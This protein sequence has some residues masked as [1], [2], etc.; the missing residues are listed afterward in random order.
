MSECAASGCG[1]PIEGVE[2]QLKGAKGDRGATGA[3]GPKGDTGAA[4]ND[5]RDGRDGATLESLRI[6][7]GDAFVDEGI[8]HNPATLFVKLTDGRE[9]IQGVDLQA[10]AG[11]DGRD[12]HDGVDG[13]K[14]DTGPAGTAGVD[15]RDGRDGADGATGPKGDTGLQGPK[16]DAGPQGIQGIQGQRG[17]TGL[18]GD[19]GLQGPKGDKGDKGDTGPQGIAGPQ[20]PAGPQGEPGTGGGGELTDDTRWQ[21]SDLSDAVNVSGNR[22]TLTLRRGDGTMTGADLNFKTINGQSTVGVGDITAAG[23]Q[24]PKGDKGDTGPAGADGMQG[25][26]GIQGPA[27][28]KGDTGLQGPAGPK[29]D[30]GATGAQGPKGDGSDDDLRWQQSTLDNTVI[31][32]RNNLTLNRGDGTSSTVF[33]L[34]K[35]INGNSLLGSG[36]IAVNGQDDTS[37]QQSALSTAIA[38]TTDLSVSFQRGNSSSTALRQP[39]KTVNGSPVI[40]T[41]NISV[42]GAQGPTGPAGPSLTDIHFDVLDP[43]GQTLDVGR[44]VKGDKGDTG[45]QGPQ[46]P[47]GPAGGSGDDGKYLYII[48][49][50]KTLPYY[51]QNRDSAI[52]LSF[53]IS[54]KN[55]RVVNRSVEDI[56]YTIG[57]AQYILLSHT[58]ILLALNAAVATF[59]HDQFAVKLVYAATDRLVFAILKNRN[60]FIIV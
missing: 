19:T 53:N 31:G 5:G 7:Q 58:E 32:N 25:P 39:F 45:P 47:Q 48:D 4:G 17:V 23:P 60:G 49:D 37:W 56:Y 11:T 41:G 3:V 13:A 42:T 22:H 14:G 40:G 43:E 12:G 30:T 15:G 2:T 9:L 36:N 27:G 1:G 52:Y 51:V 10:A 34:F 8:T 28:P 59:Y 50:P 46:G 26:Q 38:G 29:G 44:I 54:G 33:Q 24:G 6:E 57:F 16:G 18:K 35:T 21:Q 55:V 20:G